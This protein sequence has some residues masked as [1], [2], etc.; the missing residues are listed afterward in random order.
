[1]AAGQGLRISRRD[2]LRLL[3][4]LSVS[5]PLAGAGGISFVEQVAHKIQ[6]AQ[7]DI[8][9]APPAQTDISPKTTNF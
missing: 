3:S 1:M 9:T 4:A 6:P 2:L 7:R 5:A 8:S